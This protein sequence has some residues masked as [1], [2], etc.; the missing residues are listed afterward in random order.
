MQLAL[1]SF[2]SFQKEISALALLFNGGKDSSRILEKPKI[3]TYNRAARS[4]V[5][6]LFSWRSGGV[7]D[8]ET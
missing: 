7:S 4:E 3:R 8:R 1:S 6:G 2:N 5:M